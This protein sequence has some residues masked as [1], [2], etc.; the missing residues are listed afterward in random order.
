MAWQ[1]VSTRGEQGQ[2]ANQSPLTSWM[3]GTIPLSYHV[4]T[5]S[6][7]LLHIRIQELTGSGAVNYFKHATLQSIIILF[8]F[9]KWMK[10][11]PESSTDAHVG[12]NT[13]AW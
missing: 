2:Q 5:I 1:T 10:V 12:E 7:G 9:Q 3:L 11:C 6:V 4:K 8:V 13:K